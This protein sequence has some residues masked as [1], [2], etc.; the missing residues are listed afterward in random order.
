MFSNFCFSNF[1]MKTFP[2]HFLIAAKILRKFGPS[3]KLI[4]SFNR[5]ETQFRPGANLS[6]SSAHQCWV[7]GGGCE[8]KGVTISPGTQPVSLAFAWRVSLINQRRTVK[9][10]AA[11]NFPILVARW[12]VHA[13]HCPPSP[14]SSLLRQMWI[15]EHGSSGELITG[16]APSCTCLSEFIS[17]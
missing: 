14:H 12:G 16:H 10:F 1:V 5:L 9:K 8:G 7:R 15:L 6:P 3:H 17:I 11:Y 4:R 2:F 13:I